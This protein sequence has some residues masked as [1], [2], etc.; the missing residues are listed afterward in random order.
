MTERNFEQALASANAPLDRRDLNRQIGPGEPRFELYHFA[1]SLCSQKVRACLHE[2]AACYVAHDI[3]LQM[4]LLGNYD[5]DYV[6]LRL[7][8]GADQPMATSY[9]GRSSVETEGFD[10]A[11][12]PTLADLHEQR[13]IVDSVVICMHVDRAIKTHPPLVPKPLAERVAA[14]IEIVDS[15]PHVALLYGGHPDGDFR[16]QRLRENMPGVHNRKIEKLKE[17]RSRAG[18]DPKLLAAFDA[19]I[20]KEEAARNFVATP[21]SM[22]QATSETIANIAALE[23]RLAHESPWIC[24]ETFT[25]ADLFWA[26]SL[27]RLAW[28]GASF[29]WS[30]DHPL[31]AAHR[32]LVASYAERLFARSSVQ[33]AVIHWP[34]VPR[35]EFVSHHYD[36]I[37]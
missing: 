19:K 30:G 9:T 13:V 12:V 32:P 27:F 24:G 17:A 21:Q 28:L 16:P 14:E 2:K 23:D 1:L 4:P 20:S 31:N 33:S 5:P 26:V 7:M 10:P 11:V 3:N 6:R 35:S 18:D 25:L 36:D 15:T 22:R 8:G 29:C 34:G 37:D